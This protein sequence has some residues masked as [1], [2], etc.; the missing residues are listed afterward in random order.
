MKLS[1]DVQHFMLGTA[2][3]IGSLKML[4]ANRAPKLCSDPEQA[5]LLL[6]CTNRLNLLSTAQ[7]TMTEGGLK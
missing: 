3:F 2:T 4:I 6:H 5:L 1:H 7:S